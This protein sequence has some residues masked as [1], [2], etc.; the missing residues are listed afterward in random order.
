MGIYIDYARK[1]VKS[2]T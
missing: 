2:F 1:I